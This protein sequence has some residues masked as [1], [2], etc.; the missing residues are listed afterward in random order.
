MTTLL[1]TVNIIRQDTVDTHY[2]AA[3][4][5]LGDKIKFEPFRTSFDIRAGCV[6]KEITYE[7]AHR[8]NEGGIVTS[9]IDG[10]GLITQVYY[11]TANVKLP[12]SLVHENDTEKIK[13]VEIIT[14]TFN[15]ETV[16]EI[17]NQDSI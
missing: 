3:I 6:S 10:S 4:S 15:V 12:K 2:R 17:K 16:S 1:D 5:E 9:V 14:N 11:L 13:E 7:I 8:F